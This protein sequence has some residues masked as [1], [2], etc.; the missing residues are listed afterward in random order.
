MSVV[1]ERQVR[2]VSLVIVLALMGLGMS[3]ASAQSEGELREALRTAAEEVDYGSFVQ[4]LTGFAA[5]PG[6][7]AANF[8]IQAEDPGISDVQASKIVLPLTYEFSDTRI[9]GYPLYTELTLGY[10]H[11]DQQID[12]FLS[13]VPAQAGVDSNVDTFSA[14]GG[15]GLTFDLDQH[16]TLRPLV[17]IGYSYISQDSKFSGPGG[18]ILDA[19]SDGFLF[20]LHENVALTGGAVELE[21]RR[22]VGSDLKLTGNIRYNQLFAETFQA[23]DDLLET[24]GTFGVLTAFARLDGPLP[25]QAFGRDLRWITFA[26]NST[27]TGTSSRSIGF[28]YFFEL[29]GGLEVVD[30]QVIRGIE[31]VS[32]QASALLGDRVTGWS[33]GVQLE[34]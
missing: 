15:I 12:D 16:T 28:D 20:N 10:F 1:W 7:S 18:Q 4:G 34:F 5:L 21:H 31:G 26:S 14:V 33:V 3:S 32:L 11:A 2:T 19:A 22:D 13:G 29:G 9:F 27:L 17:L 24:S 30:D 8:T 23:S 6:V 25:F